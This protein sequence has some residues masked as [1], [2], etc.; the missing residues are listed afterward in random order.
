MGDVERGLY[1]VD[2]NH[3]GLDNVIPFPS[4][5]S[6]SPVGRIGRRER[7]GGVLSFN[8]RTPRES[9][10]IEFGTERGHLPGLCAPEVS[11]R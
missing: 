8:E 10:A 2:R 9:V 7:L 3:Q 11:S 5:H 4:R 1:D 6:A